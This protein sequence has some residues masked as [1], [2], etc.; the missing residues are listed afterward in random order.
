MV[1]GHAA[2]MCGAKVVLPG[3]ALDG[4]SIFDLAAQGSDNGAPLN[5]IALNGEATRR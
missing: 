5:W 4:K 2:A 1:S 3:P